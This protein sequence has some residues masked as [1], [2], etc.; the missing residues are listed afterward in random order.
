MIKMTITVSTLNVTMHPNLSCSHPPPVYLTACSRVLE[1][2]TVT[3]LV[4]KFPVF[5]ETHWF[6]TVFT[7][8]RHFSLS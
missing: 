6:I 3:I 4:V 1:K 2:L 8:A 7:K 5:Y